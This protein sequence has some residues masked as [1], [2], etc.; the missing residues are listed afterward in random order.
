M[1]IPKVLYIKGFLFIFLFNDLQ[2]F[3]Q[4]YFNIPFT[5]GILKKALSYLDR[6]MASI[7]L[8]TLDNW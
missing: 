5:T 3:K 2:K 1:H 6:A 7:V 8:N 4:N